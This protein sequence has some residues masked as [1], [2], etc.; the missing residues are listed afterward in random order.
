MNN[1]LDLFMQEMADVKPL[2]QQP[3]IEKV[4]SEPSLAQLARRAA[5]Q[6]DLAFDPNTLSNEFVEPIDPYDV[7]V[8]KKEGVQE[9][10]CKK[11]RLGKYP[12]ETRLNLNHLTV[13]EARTETFNYLKNCYQRN[14]RLI[15]IVHGIGLN[16][17]PYPAILKSHINKWLRELD[18]VLAF[19]TAIKV[20]G[21]YGATYVL[22]KKS[23]EK[24]IENRERFAKRLGK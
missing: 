4:K 14:I 9:G 5:A 11:L 1:E 17:K 21:G 20:H 16:S 2:V 23:E 19:H 3:Q 12:I 22:L 13:Q 6:N 8:Y 24:R 18:I 10:V 7:L 15:N